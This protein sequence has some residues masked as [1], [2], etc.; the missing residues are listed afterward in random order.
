MHVRCE[1]S[2]VPGQG[3]TLLIHKVGHYFLSSPL[4]KII[5]S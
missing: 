5:K 3:V 2:F 4:Q 1:L